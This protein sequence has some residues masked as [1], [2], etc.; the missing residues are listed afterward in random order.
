MAPPYLKTEYMPSMSQFRDWQ[1]LQIVPV[2][3][4][5]LHLTHNGAFR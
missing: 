3:I 2:R 1:L 5:L 4:G